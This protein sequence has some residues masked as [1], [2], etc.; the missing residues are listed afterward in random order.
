[1]KAESL[2]ALALFVVTVAL[3]ACARPADRADAAVDT[4]KA[5]Q[6]FLA[7]NAKAQGV[8]TTASGLEY[9]V[10]RSGPAAGASPK[11]ADEVKVNYEGKLL[12]GQVFDSSYDRGEP[13]VFTVRDVVPGFAEALE[14][15]RPG[16]QWLVYIPAKLGYGDKG[17]GPIPPGA[18]LVF[19]LDL[20]AVRSESAG[21]GG[22]R[23]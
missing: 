11:P 6:A 13:A 21:G 3:A 14:R 12:D 18:A 19:K 15:M 20:I 22:G 8:T 17:A 23:P 9:R 2:A 7:R 10:L 5:A 1:M 16:D 4:G